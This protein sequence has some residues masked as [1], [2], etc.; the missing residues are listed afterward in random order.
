MVSKSTIPCL[1]SINLDEEDIIN[2][3]GFEVFKMFVSLDN[4]MNY[5][6]QMYVSGDK[7]IFNFY[8]FKSMFELA[9]GLRTGQK[10]IC[11]ANFKQSKF[12][13]KLGSLEVRK[14][15]RKKQNKKDK[16]IVSR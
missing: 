1:K 6:K 15:V 10:N 12:T 8:E 7:I 2:D 11:D 9:Q 14:T 16:N 13:S 3:K 4:D 5:D